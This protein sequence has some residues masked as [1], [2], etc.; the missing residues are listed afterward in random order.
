MSRD[1]QSVLGPVLFNSFT[2]DLEEE[3]ECALI[4]LVDHSNFQGAIKMLKDRVA[5]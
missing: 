5:I 2:N 1:S 3:A 4:K